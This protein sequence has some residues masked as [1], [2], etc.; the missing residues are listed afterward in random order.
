MNAETTRRPDAETTRPVLFAFGLHLHQPVGNFDW[1]FEQ[2]VAQVYRPL[3]HEIV[4]GGAA[5]SSLHV[6]GPLLDWLEQHHAGFLDEL[7][8]W[9]SDGRVELLLAGYDEPILVTLTR[10]DRLEQ[11]GRMKEGLKTRFGVE[12]TGLWLTERVWEPHL[13][14]DLH[15]AGVRFVLVDDRHFL[16]AGFDRAE[17]HRPW[18][19]EDGGRTLDLFPIDEQLRY[20]VP[21]RPPAEF[22]AYLRGLGTQSGQGRDAE[23]PRRPAAVAVLADDGE[24]FG[25]WPGTYEW[26]Y[27]KGWLK[28]FL[29][30]LDQLQR[31]GEARLVTFSEALAEVPPRGIAYLPSAS[32]HEMEGW[33]LPAPAARRLLSLEAELGEARVKGPEGALLRGSHWRNFFAKYPEA[34]RMHKKMMTLSRLCR[35]RGDPPRARRALG[36]AQC[37]DAYWHGVFGGLY[38]PHLRNALWQ[39]LARAESDLRR[40]EG[41]GWEFSDYDCDGQ[42]ELLVHSGGVSVAISPARGGT[43][44]ELTDLS[45]LRN[46]VDTLTRR[47]EPYHEPLA[48]PTAAPSETEAV[49]IHNI[50]RRLE[51]LPPVDPDTRALFQE[52]VRPAG[53]TAD[54]LADGSAPLLHSW[55]GEPAECT[56]REESGSLVVKL[57]LRGLTKTYRIHPEGTI[58]ITLAW[59]GG[60]GWP[61]DAWFTTELSLGHPLVIEAPR[62]IELRYPIETVSQSE[63]GLDRTRQGESVTLAWPVGAGAAR[64]TL[65]FPN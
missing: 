30:T 49:S 7:G 61:D 25:G 1:V 22:A 15:E 33:A 60:R 63:S 34:N 20:L 32:Y 45:G 21:F 37:N 36:R 35:D 48:H 23:T 53:V 18:R 31:A 50:D 41:L 42:A 47:R 44:E 2:H 29:A 3:L 5:P 13:A 26:V 28:E 57:E 40:G 55:A 54:M 10:E 17:L 65:D 59:Q 24:K 14:G 8:R 27:Q 56:T 6:S 39:E 4:G 12:A 16:V 62:A 43:I 64:V 9:V 51:T 52:R 46:A 38:L 11:I 19:T 58:E